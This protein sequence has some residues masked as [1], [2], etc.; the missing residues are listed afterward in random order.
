MLILGHMH[1]SNRVAKKKQWAESNLAEILG[2]VATVL[3]KPIRYIDEML[4]VKPETGEPVYLRYDKI[5]EYLQADFPELAD[6]IPTRR[7]QSDRIGSLR[8]GDLISLD[9]DVRSLLCLI[10][11]IS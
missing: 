4:T 1:D 11:T 6:R 5:R 3:A 9:A 8:Q 7:Y 2:D 10:A